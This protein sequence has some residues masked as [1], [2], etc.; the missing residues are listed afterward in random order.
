MHFLPGS[1]L[2]SPFITLAVYHPFFLLCAP[3]PAVLLFLSISNMT[4]PWINARCLFPI[5]PSAPILQLEPLN[6]TSIVARWKT[7]SES[8]AVQGY[9]LCYHEEGHPEQP[10]VQLQAQN[11]TYTISGLGE[12]CSSDAVFFQALRWWECW[13]GNTQSY[14]L[15]LP[16]IS[17]APFSPKWVLIHWAVGCLFA[18]LPSVLINMADPS[19]LT[20]SP[21]QSGVIAWE[22]PSRVRGQGPDVPP[23]TISHPATCIIT[24]GYCVVFWARPAL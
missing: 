3:C 18:F 19:R 14:W 9:R 4:V 24:P 21:L 2:N 16:P 23:T 15:G 17:V 1:C 5:V 8:V 22:Q 11:F 12:W 6:C 7:S 10:T 20:S 13:T